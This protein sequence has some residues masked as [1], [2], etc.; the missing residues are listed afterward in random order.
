M[1][2][3][4]GTAL[5]S[6]SI[7]RASAKNFAAQLGNSNLEYPP[8]IGTEPAIAPR[9]TAS[10]SRSRWQ[11]FRS[12]NAVR[13]L[14]RNLDTPDTCAQRVQLT[15]IWATPVRQQYFARGTHSASYFPASQPSDRC[16]FAIARAA[17]SA[18]S[19]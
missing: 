2:G 7:I 6:R 19:T 16:T 3:T 11:R 8:Q 15:L 14:P 17:F 13:A 1:F 9:E 4:G 5:S 10:R 12:D 18:E